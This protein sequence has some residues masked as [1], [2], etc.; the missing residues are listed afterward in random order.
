VLI[1]RYLHGGFIRAY[2]GDFLVVIFLYCLM[3]SFLNT[4]VLPTACWIL[5]FA[6]IVEISQYFHLITLLGL[7]HSRM[8]K[9]ILGTTFS[10]IDMLTYTLGI[11]LFIMVEVLTSKTWKIIL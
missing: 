9:L 6:Y 5:V 8:A 4:A 3:K 1:A 2:G 10:M 11:L 7:Q